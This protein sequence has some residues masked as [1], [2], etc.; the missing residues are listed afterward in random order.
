M[1]PAGQNRTG[2]YKAT[3]L[4]LENIANLRTFQLTEEIYHWHWRLR[5]TSGRVLQQEQ[6]DLILRSMGYW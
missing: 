2:G 4:E 6:E 1:F 3:E 5:Q